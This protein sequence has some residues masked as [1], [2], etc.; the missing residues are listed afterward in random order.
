[1]IETFR[2]AWKIADLR[3]K[4]LYTLFIMILFR[5]GSAIPVPF[6]DP[7]AL[8]QMFQGV[9]FFGYMD[10]MAGGALSNG[11]IFAL[12]I[13]PYITA[14]I[15]IQLLTIAIEPLQRMSKEGEEGR[16]KLNNITRY[17]TIAL[18]LITGYGFY[19]LLAYRFNA[20]KPQGWFTA[21]V[22]V[23]VLTAGASVIMWM[24]EK[25]NAKGIGNGISMILFA[26]IISKLPSGIYKL[27]EKLQNGSLA[28]WG[29]II[30]VV[31]A[32]LIITAIV[33][34]N[35]AERRIP[36]QYAK[37]VVGRKMYGGQSTHIPIKVTM[38]GVLPIIF[39]QSF[40]SMP[41]MI[42]TF[43]NVDVSKGFWRWL[44]YDH[45]FYGIMLF[46]L[47]IAFAYFYT[48]V[49]FDPIDMANNMKRNGGFIPGIRPGKPTTDYLTSILN[50]TIFI[51]AAGMVIIVVIP[52][53]F[54]GVFN[55]QVSFGG[56]SIII[57]V[58]VILE[59]LKQIEAK[60]PE[61]YYSHKTSIFG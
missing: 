48:T 9:N 11:T 45:W 29:L 12:S 24:G 14:S 19:T 44:N 27:Y 40:V 42:A 55:A 35:E 53:F 39:A 4:I 8:T 47:I 5:I 34:M 10:L 2:N 32:I 30:V 36:V 21:L 13:S 59:T 15:V 31:A 49:Q 6:I 50:Y 17:L 43:F 46:I 18:S 16:R 54:N 28:W 60:I 23:A 1:M 37:R 57:I 38:S 61:Y 22:I 7:S 25:V 56:T 33:V 51:G 20:V 3:K 58:G 26:G 52:F 41:V